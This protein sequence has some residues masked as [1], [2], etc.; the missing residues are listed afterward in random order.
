MAELSATVDQLTAR[1]D[2]LDFSELPSSTKPAAPAVS[3]KQFNDLSKTVS[4]LESKVSSLQ[5]AIDRIPRNQ[6]Q[7][8]TTNRA[9]APAVTQSATPS[10]GN[11]ESTSR[12]TA[13][14]GRVS[15]TAKVKVEDRY[16]EGSTRLPNVTTGPEGK[17]IVGVTINYAGSVTTARIQSGSTISDEDI[18]DA[19]KEAALKTRFSI[20]VSGSDRH[21]ATITYTFTVK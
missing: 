2:S 6:A 17:V 12:A 7:S 15:V 14:Y 10:S 1:L 9:T 16:V 8:G 11:K 18:L 19:C 21:P 5:S 20:N 4:N 13:S 3:A